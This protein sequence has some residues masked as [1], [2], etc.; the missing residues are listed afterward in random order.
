MAK[1][2]SKL[3]Q[4]NFVHYIVDL[5]HRKQRGKARTVTQQSIIEKK[6]NISL[7]ELEASSCHIFQQKLHLHFRVFGQNSL[8]KRKTKLCSVV[9]DQTSYYSNAALESKQPSSRAAL[10]LH[11][12]K[13]VSALLKKEERL[14][15]SNRP[16]QLS[17]IAEKKSLF[18]ERVRY[19]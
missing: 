12:N 8:Q 14:N 9:W 15:Y 2:P 19:C 3:L 10:R 4:N 11:R 16:R 6:H 17:N 13:T 18:S 7:M 5:L 1:N